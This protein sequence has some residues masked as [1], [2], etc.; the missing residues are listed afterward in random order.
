M[1]VLRNRFLLFGGIIYLIY[2]A[3]YILLRRPLPG[4][5]E[6][7][8]W[9]S[10]LLLIIAIVGGMLWLLSLIR[11]IA[12]KFTNIGWKRYAVKGLAVICSMIVIS[13]AVMF[14]RI[15]LSEIPDETMS[16]RGILLVSI[17]ES[18]DSMRLYYCEEVNIFLRRKL[19]A[20]DFRQTQR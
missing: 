5:I 15:L 2:L 8:A 3:V 17:Q 18:K 10:V 14:G 7:R 1:R 12:G 19:S 9:V 16:T 6:I 20:E 11:I 4:H 13:G